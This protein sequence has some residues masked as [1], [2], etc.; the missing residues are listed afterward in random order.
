MP[1]RGVYLFALLVIGAPAVPEGA[2]HNFASNTTLGIG[3][4]VYI[5]NR[6]NNTILRMKE[7]GPVLAVRDHGRS[8]SISCERAG[9]LGRNTDHL[10]HGNRAGPSKRRLADPNLLSGCEH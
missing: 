10:D 3:S 1:K 4:D 7:S 2:A 6:G 5:L 8:R 9:R